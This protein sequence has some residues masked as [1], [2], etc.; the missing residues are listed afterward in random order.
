[1]SPIDAEDKA[2]PV[3]GHALQIRGLAKSFH[4]AGRPLEVLADIDLAVGQ[5][6]FL[7]IVGASGCGKSTL[8]RLILGLD[9]DFTGELR[10]DGRAVQGPGADRSIV[11]QDHRLLPWLDVQGNVAAALR[12]RRIGKAEK[13]A[14]VADNLRLVG[15]DRFANAYPAQLSG[16]MAQRVA[17]ARALVNQPRFLLLDEP[18]GALDALTRLR[19]QDE[20]KRITRRE[21]MTTVLVTHDVDE[22]VY[23]GDWIAVMHPNPGRIAQVVEVPSYMPRSRSDSMFIALRDQVLSLLAVHGEPT[24]IAAHNI[25]MAAAPRL[26]TAPRVRSGPQIAMAQSA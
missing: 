10:V 7:S 3:P 23:L 24:E 9:R 8:L 18:L 12:R 13:R 11:F 19:L 6:E 26:G 16:G 17:I 20:L 1:M 21:G 14:L 15:L 25:D 4:V 2:P 22:A 5:G